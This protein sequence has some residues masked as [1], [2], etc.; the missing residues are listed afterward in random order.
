MLNSPSRV[1][2]LNPKHAVTEVASGE[3]SIKATVGGHQRTVLAFRKGE[4]QTVVH[5]VP[6]RRRDSECGGQERHQRERLDRHSAEVVEYA[7]GSRAFHL[8]SQLLL[9]ERVGELSA[10]QLGRQENSIG[11]GHPERRL[12]QRLGQEPFDDETG[13]DHETVHLSR[14]SRIRSVL[15]DRRRPWNFSCQARNT[16]SASS[17][18]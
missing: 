18:V 14:S 16:S 13:V 4:V 3:G 12:G 2:G 1:E 6:G 8:A 11:G 10:E 7:R 15:S 17:L 9:P 5:A